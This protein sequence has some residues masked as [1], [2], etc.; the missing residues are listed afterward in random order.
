MKCF[1][2]PN[3]DAVGVCKSC[4]R[5]LCRDCIAAVG[6]SCSCKGEC[7]AVVAAQND[8]VE[9]G[10]TAYQKS[11]AMQMRSG[12]LVMLLGGLFLF[13]GITRLGPERSTWDYFL[14]GA[15]LLFT[16]LG[17]SSM[18]SAIRFKQK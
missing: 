4:G 8:L 12:I 11:S 2:H 9:R 13:F 1:N 10:R 5:G 15:G 17:L 3:T 14:L 6:L 16:I 18:Y 7:E